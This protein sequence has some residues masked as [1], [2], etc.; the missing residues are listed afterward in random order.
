M[1]HHDLIGIPFP[2]D[3]PEFTND[4]PLKHLIFRIESLIE[5]G[6]D[7]DD[8][9]GLVTAT[10]KLKDDHMLS[11]RLGGGLFGLVPSTLGQSALLIYARCFNSSTRRTRLDAPDIFTSTENLETHANIM[12]IRDRFIAHQGSNANQH[13]LFVLPGTDGREISLNPS[14]QTSRLIFDS[15]IDWSKFILNVKTIQSYVQERIHQ[16]CK[17]VEGHLSEKQIDVINSMD[18]G[19]SIGNHFKKIRAKTNKPFD[20]RGNEP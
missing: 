17:R 12:A 19:E 9:L 1:A 4:Q 7:L 2:V 8:I 6:H 15:A 20:T 14:G 10:L 16:S 11:V 3:H 18:V 13:H 5:I